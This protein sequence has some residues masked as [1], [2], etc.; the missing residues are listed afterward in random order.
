MQPVGR[1]PVCA[2]SGVET[3]PVKRLSVVAPCFNEAEGLAELHRRVSAVCQ[4]VAG[5]DYEIVLVNDGSRDDTWKMMALLAV[6]DPHV[7]AINL[8]RNYGHQVALTAGLDHCRGRRILIIDADLQDPPELLPQMLSLMNEGADVVYGQRRSRSGESRFK[9]AATLLY[10]RLLKRLVDIDIP[11]DTGDFRLISRRV[12][13]LLEAM[14]EQTRFIRG[15]VSWMGL[16]QVP[17]IYDRDQRF[18]GETGYPLRKLITLALDGITG[19][20][21]VP[22][23]IASYFGLVTGICGLGMLAYT[24]GGWLFAKAPEGWASTTTIILVIGSAQLLVLGIV[25]EYLGRLYMESKRRPLYLV[26]TVVAQAAAFAPPLNAPSAAAERSAKAAP[27]NA[28]S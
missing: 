24:L 4:E 16:R 10:Y 5:E 26:D 13:E 20:S 21:V 15:M 25:G 12:L 6:R 18:A 1:C 17:L 22:L 2:G 19:F 3:G 9:T 8:T 23:R 27:R 14:P 28:A 11:L 7:V